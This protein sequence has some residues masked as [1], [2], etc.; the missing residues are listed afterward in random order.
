MELIQL[1][2]FQKVAQ[3]CNMTKSAEEL[4]VTTSALSKAILKLEEEWGVSLFRREK[5]RIYLTTV[6]EE[7]LRYVK[8]ALSVLEKLQDTMGKRAEEKITPHIACCSVDRSP[9]R[10]IIPRWEQ[11]DYPIK[12]RFQAYTLEEDCIRALKNDLADVAVLYQRSNFDAD[13]CWTPVFGDYAMLKIPRSHPLAGAKRLTP[14]DLEGIPIYSYCDALWHRKYNQLLQESNDNKF[15]FIE[16][17]DPVV[18]QAKIA[19]GN[20]CQLSCHGESQL[21]LNDSQYAFVPLACNHAQ[22]T[23]YMVYLK[24]NAEKLRPSLMALYRDMMDISSVD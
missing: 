7:A 21:Y 15:R 9:E 3:S 19:G 24:R 6:G 11:C 18:Y 2:Y 20:C 8:E 1:K 16:I 14:S 17:T 23:Y 10:T 12:V 22:I 4:Y 13:L 5:K